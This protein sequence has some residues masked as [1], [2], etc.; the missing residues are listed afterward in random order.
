MNEHA[1]KNYILNIP[2]TE[3]NN[4]FSLIKK[5]CYL[6]RKTA[7]YVYFHRLN[8]LLDYYLDDRHQIK[9]KKLPI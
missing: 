6:G 5:Q 7:E 1:Y 2:N 3:S 9:M 4:Q 8:D